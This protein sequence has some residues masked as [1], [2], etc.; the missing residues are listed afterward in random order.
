MIKK[1]WRIK[2]T[3]IKLTQI[4]F[5]NQKETYIPVTNNGKLIEYDNIEK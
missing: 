3:E 4:N 5:I 1:R 2:L